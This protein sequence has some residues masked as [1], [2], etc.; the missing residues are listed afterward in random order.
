LRKDEDTYIRVVCADRARGAQATV[1]LGR[2][3]DVDER[4]V[5]L[6]RFHLLEQLLCISGLPDD[7]EAG[8]DQK[9]RHPLAQQDG[10]VGED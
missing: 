8:L 3:A 9:A 1:V 6:V 7:L 2:H 5:R 4:D 10:V